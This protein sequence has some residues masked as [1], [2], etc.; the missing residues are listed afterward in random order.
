MALPPRRIPPD[1]WVP[2]GVSDLERN[3]LLV[4]KSTEH[5]SVLAGPGAGK[6]ELLA[7]RAAYLLQTGLCPAP[8]RILAISFKRDAARNLGDRV[9]QRCHTEHASR[10]DSVTFDALSKSLVDRFGQALP[11]H[12]RPEPDYE[13]LLY[14]KKT[15]FSD[16]LHWASK[17]DG[18]IGTEAEIHAIS[19]ETFERRHVLAHPLPVLERRASTAAMWAG[20][21]FWRE[22]LH[23]GGETDLT[24][25]MIGRLAELLLRVNSPLRLALSL[26]YSHVFMD[27]FQD[28]TQVQYD[29]IRTMF[30]STDAVITAVGDNK[31]QIM[32]FALA[33]AD[34][35]QVFESDFAAVRT[36]L[37]HNY[38]SSPELVRI[39]HVLA[40]AVDASTAVAVA[41]TFGTVSGDSCVI[42]DFPSTEAEAR[43]LARFAS[44]QMAEHQL[45]QTDIVLLVRQKA[46]SYASVLAPHF[47]ATG[48][49]LR[50]EDASVGAMKV[51]DLMADELSVLVVGLLRIATIQC[52]GAA[53]V[54]TLQAVAFLRSIQHDDDVGRHK[55]ASQLDTFAKRLSA[56][57]PSPPATQ[58]EA[59]PI[60]SAIAEFVDRARLIAVHPAYGQGGWLEKVEL[61]IA[62]HLAASAQ[63]AASWHEA[64]DSYVG[65]DSLPLMTIHKSKGLE[66]NTVIFVG[67]DDDAWWSFRREPDDAL[68]GFFVAFT[69]AKQRVVFAY[70]GARGQRRNIA[71]LYDLLESAGVKRLAPA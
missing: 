26:T 49:R 35:F 4:V 38:R 42:W 39:Q 69:R 47:A 3:A 25:P 22:M 6:T 60:V 11:P 10:F 41:K 65:L 68:A 12:W 37:T 19:P 43:Y 29:L 8:R 34:P 71:P 40:Q 23:R 59:V 33:M 15:F 21:V 58:E 53:W 18:R 14:P 67:L 32:R 28:A 45:R 46:E 57:Y 52:A 55:L 50:N 44:I 31:Q 62:A 66:Y 2:I 1:K 13:L 16:F 5:R 54:D 9:R 17:A 51:Q 36:P 20:D 27:E 24:F 7:Q 70:C 56:T 64:L 63:G 61:S 48:I 30:L